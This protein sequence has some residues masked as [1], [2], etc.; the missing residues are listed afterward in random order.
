MPKNSELKY[1]AIRDD[2]EKFFNSGM[3]RSTIIKHLMKKYY[4]GQPMIYRILEVRSLRKERK[5]IT[6]KLKS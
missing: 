6:R 3:K 1:S 2:Y 5:L 4:L